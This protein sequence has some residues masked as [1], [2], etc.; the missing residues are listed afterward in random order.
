[1][2]SHNYPPF[3]YYNEDGRLV[4]FNI[5]VLNAIN[6]LYNNQIEIEVG[7]WK[8]INLKFE[9]GKIQ[10]IA[11]VH[12]PG[13]D[14]NDC[15]YTRS[16][17]NT[18][19]CFFYNVEDYSSFSFDNLRTMSQPK[20][21]IWNNEVLKDYMLAI[22]PYTQFFYVNNYDEVLTAL[23]NKK[24][25]CA[26]AQRAAMNHY[27]EAKGV[28]DIGASNL[29]VLERVMGFK[30]NKKNPELAEMLNNGLEEIMLN[31]T[32]HKLYDKWI[33]N[34]LDPEHKWKKVERGLL[35]IGILIALG[36]IL[37]IIFNR[38]LRNQVKLK[39]SHLEEQLNLNSKIR[40]E[41]VDAK[42][43]AEVSDQMK[44]S[45]LANMSHEIRTPMNG[46][47]GFS[48]LLKEAEYGS[49]EQSYFI[50]LIQKSGARMLSTINNIIDISKIQSGAESLIIKDVDVDN[51]V[52]ELHDFFTPEAMEKGIGLSVDKKLDSVHCIIRTDEY[53]L[54]SVLSNL[55]KNAIKFTNRGEII[56][57]YEISGSFARFFVKDTGIGIHEDKHEVIFNKFTRADISYSSEFEGSGLGLSIAK[58][59]V[60]MLDGKMW[61]ESEIDNGSIFYFEIPRS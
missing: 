32:Y 49:E 26:L 53:K 4:G 34:Y 23:E 43:K 50:D 15:Y 16:V 55:I 10:A 30:V 33:K 41:L 11:G 48:E 47:L 19:H 37:L 57:G 12:Y 9:E 14:A 40:E 44:S 38:V 42:I 22:N 29:L 25:I 60:H 7:D 56:L 45:F 1:M 21:A 36:A 2:I 3:H 27:I 31:G 58:E 52:K 5:D 8:D 35:I 17:V 18:Y 39:T 54:H 28:K 24:V 61:L 51:M 6:E 59:Y 13:T 46:I 20:V